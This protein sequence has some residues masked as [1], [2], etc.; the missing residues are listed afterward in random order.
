MKYLFKIRAAFFFYFLMMGVGTASAGT[1]ANQTDDLSPIASSAGLPFRIVIEKAD[2][3]LPVGIHSGVFGEYHGLWVFIAGR[4]NGMH[5]FGGDPFPRDEQNKSIYVVNP[6]TGVVSSRL[7]SDPSSGLNQQQIDILSVTSP[8]GYQ[9]GTTLYMVGGYGENTGEGTFETKSFLTA[10]NLPGIIQWVTQPGNKNNSV[11]KNIQQISNPLFQITGGRMFKLGNLTQLVFGQNF[12]GVYADNRNGEYSQQV[13][14]F[15]IKSV[16]GQLAVDI[17]PSRPSTPNANYRRRDLN[18][19]PMMLNNNN[20]LQY[21]LVAYA[22]VFTPDTGVWT[23]PVVIGEAG[24][25]VMNDPTLSTTFKQGMNQYVCATTGLY[26]RKY[27]SMYTIFFGGISYGYYSNGVFSTDSEIPFINQ[28]TTV[29][30][31]TNGSFTQHLMDAQYPVIL[32]TRSNPGNTL[33]FGAG[34][35]FIPNNILRYPNAVISLDNIRSDTVIGYIVG[36]IESTLANTN[37]MADSAASPYVF[38]VRL[39]PTA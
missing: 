16:R 15:Q 6:L 27:S 5:G 36:G 32:S 30:M 2:F 37:T 28:V 39:I 1:T 35:Y 38:K 10:I 22:G 24:D 9:D 14:Q 17:Y 26:S 3:E 7:L 20:A 13:R 29:Q 34:A 19:V 31:D 33:L 11:A 25:P 12:T 8:E 23:V 21:G 18:V 4:I